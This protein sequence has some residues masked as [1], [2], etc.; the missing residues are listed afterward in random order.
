[1]INA[2]P[3]P[4][5]QQRLESLRKLR[6][7][8]TPI[9][10]R[11]ERLTRMVCRLMDVPIS[12]FNLIGDKQQFLKSVQGMEDVHPQFD[13]SFCPHTFHEPDVMVIEDASNDARF[14]DSPFVTVD[15]GIRFYAG[16]AVK[17]PD[18]MP[19][20]TVCA[21][22]TK[23]RQMTAD[24]LDALRDI[25]AMVETELRAAFIQNEKEELETEL[26]Q[27]NRL[28][29]IDPMTRVWNRAGMETILNKEWAESRRKKEII[30]LVMCDIDH[31]KKIND[32]Y[33]HAAGDDVIRGVAKKLIEHVRAEDHVCRVGG[34][35]FLIILPTCS[36][37]N[38]L[39]IMERV[40][41][42]IAET[43]FIERND[44]K[45]TTM[46][47]G[48]SG[49]VPNMD[50]APGLL[51][52]TADAALYDAKNGGRNRVVVRAI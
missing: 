25:A 15:S 32:T 27:A 35:E 42:A 40:R 10:E 22:D 24:Q 47:F 37:E 36:P 23:P 28:A 38:A 16:C 49:I 31:F 51:I 12:Y 29:L 6:M 2:K 34:E 5:E 9:E 18:G 14:Q 21:I 3:Y 48:V 45:N 39:T 52:K 50:T 7:L 30:T 19:V 8:E 33:G 44:G 26:E 46:S 41:A 17:T 20:G 1:M 43:K 13:G 11:F 4:L